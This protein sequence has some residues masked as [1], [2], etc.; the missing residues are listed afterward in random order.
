MAAQGTRKTE[1]A[2]S[3]DISGPSTGRPLTRGGAARA[4]ELKRGE[5]DLAVQ[6]G[7]VRA[8]CGVNGVP[9]SVAKEEIDRLR[10]ADGF[11]DVLRNRVRTV[12][13]AEGAA[14]V[15]I[16]P[17]RF[18]RLARTGHF[19]PVRFYLNRY[20][21]VVW[22]YL[23]EELRDFTVIHPELLRG[24]IPPALR[25]M[26]DAGADRRPR[27]WRTRRLGLQLRT[28]EDPWGR[29]AAIASLLAPGTVAH[30]VPD[31]CER[32]H[33][34][35]LR[36]EFVTARP[37]SPTAREVVGRLLLADD[38]DEIM[39]HRISLAHELLEAREECPAPRPAE[40]GVGDRAHRPG[41]A[42]GPAALRPGRPAPCEPWTAA[43]AVA[44][45]PLA[46]L[47]AAHP[48]MVPTKDTASVPPP[49]HRP[50]SG[51]APAAD[52]RTVPRGGRTVPDRRAARGRGLLALLRFK[53]AKPPI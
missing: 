31:P 51:T 6:L 52:S 53:R 25:T 47:P 27:N 34:Q 37:V 2:P 1:T 18:T 45:T 46:T 9:L 29:A 3:R 35:A 38:P 36:P 19:T 17:A 43:R 44:G 7:Q 41:T 40:N 10:A 14:L 32:S 22:L 49:R 26:L 30:V 12:G 28:T 21:A 42:V 23:A 4:L 33:L 11:P 24:R 16:T 8:A 13:T 39:W 50:R 20:R 5:F 48:P 15:S